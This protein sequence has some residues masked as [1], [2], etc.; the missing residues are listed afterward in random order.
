MFIVGQ[1][2]ALNQVVWKLRHFS[3]HKNHLVADIDGLFIE[4]AIFF[5]NL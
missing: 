5:N 4:R 2:I 1:V 3:Q